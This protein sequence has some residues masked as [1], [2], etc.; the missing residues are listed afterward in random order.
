MLR[1]G[2]TCKDHDHDGE[3]LERYVAF[4]AMFHQLD[5]KIEQGVTNG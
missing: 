3:A 2:G 4:K 5:R 1:T